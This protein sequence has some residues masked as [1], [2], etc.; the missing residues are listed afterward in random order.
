M[1]FFQIFTVKIKYLPKHTNFFMDP[2]I[3]F[4]SFDKAI[5]S[6]NIFVVFSH[7]IAIYKIK[8]ELNWS[9]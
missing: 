2:F 9:K 7:F 4:A 3:E 1:D 8:F 5:P 6:S